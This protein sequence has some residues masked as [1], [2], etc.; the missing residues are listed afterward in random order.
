MEERENWMGEWI[1][2]GKGECPGT[3]VV[4]DKRWSESQE[5]EWNS[6]P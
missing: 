5:N 6:A 4:R 3:G 2:K 1:S